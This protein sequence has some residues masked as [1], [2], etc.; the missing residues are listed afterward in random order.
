MEV[1]VLVKIH[2]PL[3]TAEIPFITDIPKILQNTETMG[4]VTTWGLPISID[5]VRPYPSIERLKPETYRCFQ[6][7]HYTLQVFLMYISA[8]NAEEG[9]NSLVQSTR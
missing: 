1:Q 3:T 8:E 5:I 6:L 9:P 7:K 2:V 4:N